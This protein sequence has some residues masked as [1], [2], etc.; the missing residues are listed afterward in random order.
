MRQTLQDTS[1]S[2]QNN[3][4][5]NYTTKRKQSTI[6]KLNNVTYKIHSE[7]HF[8]LYCRKLNRFYK[9]HQGNMTE[10]NKNKN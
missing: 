4:R 3:I 1:R 5:K 8:R 9:S 10:T 7:M 6:Y 2:H